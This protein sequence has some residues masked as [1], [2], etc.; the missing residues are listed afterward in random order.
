MIHLLLLKRLRSERKGGRRLDGEI[1]TC[2]RELFRTHY[3]TVVRKI[4]SLVNRR[5]VAEDL[6]QEVFLRL[7]RHPPEDLSRVGPWLHRVSVRLAYDYLRFS[8]R[9]RQLQQRVADQEAAA[10]SAHPSNEQIVF[11]EWE[12]ERVK[13]VLAQL[14]ERDRRA[15]LLRHSG[16]TYQ[17][18]AHIL[19]VNSG[20][21]GTI[22]L[23]AAARFKKQYQREEG[24]ADEGETP[25]RCIHPAGF[26]R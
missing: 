12:R 2:Y 17:E 7:Y 21:V 3:Q 26:G 20:S 13:R 1:P 22:L 9:Q 10:E 15:L 5:D 6:A 11:Q 16:Y 8:V 19:Q 4:Q 18:I 14:P 23:R 25:V 24:A